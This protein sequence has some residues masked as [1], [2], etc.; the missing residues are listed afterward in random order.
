MDKKIFDLGLA[1]PGAVEPNTKP[2]IQFDRRG[3]EKS[4]TVRVSKEY[5]N[6][7]K[8]DE[9][10]THE[11]GALGKTDY[12][13]AMPKALLSK[14]SFKKGSSGKT[15]TLDEINQIKQKSE[16]SLMNFGGGSKQECT[17]YRKIN[18][19]P[20]INP[21]SELGLYAQKVHS[22]L[23]SSRINAESILTEKFYKKE[24]LT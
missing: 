8:I 5:L 7:G 2:S 17:S 9:N 20:L 10:R 23:R 11:T 15:P 3:T 14:G 21:N 19:S 1:R 13:S 18:S 4:S 16:R 6:Q 24:K 12:G 22:D